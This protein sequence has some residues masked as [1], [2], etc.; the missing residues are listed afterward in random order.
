VSDLDHPGWLMREVL[1]PREQLA[2]YVGE[3]PLVGS[4]AYEA[5]R[6]AAWRPRLGQESDH[7][8]IPHEVD[9][10]R[11][12]VH[13]SKGCY[14]GQET[15]ARVHN[16]GRPPR[17][18]VLLHLDGSGHGLPDHGADVLLEDRKVG[19]VTTA[20]R[21]YELGPIALALVK[22]N[23]PADATLLTEG[24]AAAQEIVVAP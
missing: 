14:R 16:L 2:A 6:V 18:L 4:W 13:L 15:V 10:L 5:L 23:T 12:A 21:H 11:T 19:S 24:I 8:T 3:Q 17:R 1:V 7:R 20:A 9:W 22:R